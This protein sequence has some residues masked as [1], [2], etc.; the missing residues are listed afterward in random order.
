M[1]AY[2]G[3]GGIFEFTL[4][5]VYSFCVVS[6]TPRPL[7]PAEKAPGSHWVGPRNSQRFGEKNLAP[8]AIRTPDCLA[9]SLVTVLVMLSEG[10]VVRVQALISYSGCRGTGP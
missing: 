9:H 7:Y 10:K 6:L 8:A 1:K 3:S 5:V 4:N 2:R